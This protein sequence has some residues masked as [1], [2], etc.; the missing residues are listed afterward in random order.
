MRCHV[1]RAVGPIPVGYELDGGTVLPGA[2]DTSAWRGGETR[3]W[4]PPARSGTCA[5]RVGV[6]PPRPR[7]EVLA[8]RVAAPLRRDFG[9]VLYCG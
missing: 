8:E 9:A 3:G 5:N 7:G 4:H 2:R 6:F 1:S